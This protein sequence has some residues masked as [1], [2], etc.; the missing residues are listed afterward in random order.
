MLTG[1]L[2]L[3]PLVLA[4]LFLVSGIAKVRH[5]EATR[6]AFTQLR[7]PA[8][9]SRGPAPSMLPW[10]E[11]VLAVV[12]V[13]APPPAALPVAVLALLL[14]LGYLAVVV[15]A[16]GFEHPVTCGCFGDLGLGEVTPRTA[17]RNLL[18]VVLAGLTVWSA[19]ADRSVASRLLAAPA[20]TWVWLTLVGLVTLTLVVSFGRGQGAGPTEHEDELDYRRQP[21]PFASLEDAEGR[22]WSLAELVREGAVLLVFLSPGC[23]PCQPVIARLDDWCGA[24]GPV[25]VRAVVSQPLESATTRSPELAGRTLRDPTSLAARIF[26]VGTPG[27]VLLGGDGLLAGGPVTGRDAVLEFVEDVRAELLE[28]GAISADQ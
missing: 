2:L 8:A 21:I 22:G 14:V 27:A 7:L 9:L 1:P 15:R 12:L 17:V 13:L 4:G 6:S 5:T 26:G 11:I 25:R 16:L 18:L 3:P 20:S 28:A 10:A 19:T 23:S 24:L